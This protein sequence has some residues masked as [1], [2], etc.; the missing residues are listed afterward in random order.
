MRTAFFYEE[1]GQSQRFKVHPI[2]DHSVYLAE[3]NARLRFKPAT[4]EEPAKLISLYGVLLWRGE[5]VSSE[6]S[7]G[8]H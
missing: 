5:R 1:E 4:R 6:I 8:E 2:N 3:P 7:I